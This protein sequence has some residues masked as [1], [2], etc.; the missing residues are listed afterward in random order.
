MNFSYFFQIYIFS[1]EFLSLCF[2]LEIFSNPLYKTIK[3]HCETEYISKFIGLNN[4]EFQVYLEITKL[5]LGDFDAEFKI[6]DPI[7]HNF[8]WISKS[9]NIQ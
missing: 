8:F 3:F 4:T 9:I 7:T 2:I 5:I 6:N 1:F